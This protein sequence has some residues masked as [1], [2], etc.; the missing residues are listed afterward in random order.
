MG[1]NQPKHTHNFSPPLSKHPIIIGSNGHRSIPPIKLKI[2]REKTQK[3][4]MLNQFGVIII[5]GFDSRE[6]SINGMRI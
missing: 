2:F 1:I 5:V 3:T 4:V 6:R